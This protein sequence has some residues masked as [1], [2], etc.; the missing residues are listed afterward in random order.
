MKGHPVIKFLE[1][2][3]LFFAVVGALNWGLVAWFKF[4]LVVLIAQLWAPLAW[5]LYTIVGVSGLYMLVYGA[6][7]ELLEVFE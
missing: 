6:R 5:I 1:W 4:D 7:K 3:A 2:A